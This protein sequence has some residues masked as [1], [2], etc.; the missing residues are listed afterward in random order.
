MPAASL[1]A[2]P[3]S[4]FLSSFF[5]CLQNISFF[6]AFTTSPLKHLRVP[7]A[8]LHLVFK[9]AASAPLSDLNLERWTLADSD[10]CNAREGNIE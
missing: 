10:H 5:Q 3:S 6:P 9:Y 1:T 2:R 4:F 8:Q 7:L